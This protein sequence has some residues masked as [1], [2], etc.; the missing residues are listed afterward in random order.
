MLSVSDMLG[1]DAPAQKTQLYFLDTDRDPYLIIGKILNDHEARTKFDTLGNDKSIN[2]A[3]AP[4]CCGIC[5]YLDG[6]ETKIVEKGKNT[7]TL[8]DYIGSRYLWCGKDMNK[9]V[10]NDGYNSELKATSTALD[11]FILNSYNQ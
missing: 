1:M 9:L 3:Y 2:I 6:D 5:K 8:Y 7:V 10:I 4:C 11:D